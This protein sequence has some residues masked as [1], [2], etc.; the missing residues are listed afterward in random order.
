MVILTCGALIFTYS[1]VFWNDLFLL[2]IVS[3][4]CFVCLLFSSFYIFLSFFGAGGQ[5]QRLIC[6]LS[7]RK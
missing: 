7:R 2:P 1:V 6:F 4:L 5:I 3:F